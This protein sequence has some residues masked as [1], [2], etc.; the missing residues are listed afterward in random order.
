MSEGPWQP[1]SAPPPLA[2]TA[3]QRS[4]AKPN[5]PAS[6]TSPALPMA[7]SSRRPS[8]KDASAYR[9]QRGIA[10]PW[11]HRRPHPSASAAD[12]RQRRAYKDDVAPEGIALSPALRWQGPVQRTAGRAGSG[13][14]LGNRAFR[15][16]AGAGRIPE[17]PHVTD[18]HAQ[19]DTAFAWQHSNP[20]RSRPR[21][22]RA[23]RPRRR[24][25][26]PICATRPSISSRPNTTIRWNCSP[27]RRSGTDGKLTV[28]DKTQGVQNVQRYLCGVFE[29]QPDEVQVM[30]PYMG[31]GFGAGLRPQYQ[32][33]L[34]VLAARAL[35]RSV[36]VVLTARRCMG[37]VIARR[38][39]SVSHSAPTPAARSMPSC[40]RRSR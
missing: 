6:S 20:S 37:S 24:L 17:E 7:M 25:R 8:P 27:R 30:S 35:K 33:V 31:G 22:S 21:Q 32:V 36:R 23:A 10:R 9:R 2:S 28:Y 1:I 38:R 40:T 19:R 12:G 4:P 26:R 3:G 29:M 15:R 39:S 11:R 13:R 18:L 5:M 16:V 14:G 34:A